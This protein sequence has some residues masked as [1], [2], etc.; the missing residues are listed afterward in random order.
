MIARQV[1][2]S[3]QHNGKRVRQLAQAKRIVKHSILQTDNV[4][5]KAEFRLHPKLGTYSADTELPMP[6]HLMQP[7]QYS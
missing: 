4:P 1:T 6:M 3:W 7:A 2:I 5:R